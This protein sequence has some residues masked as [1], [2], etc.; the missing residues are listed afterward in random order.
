MYYESTNEKDKIGEYDLIFSIR[1]KQMTE[2]ILIFIILCFL[3]VFFIKTIYIIY[4]YIGKFIT[5][6]TINDQKIESKLLPIS[7]H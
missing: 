7:L 5:K 6:Q 2:I 1:E 4:I 3:L